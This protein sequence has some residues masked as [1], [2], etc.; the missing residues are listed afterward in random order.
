LGSLIERY[1]PAMFRGIERGLTSEPGVPS[2][3]GQ[4]PLIDPQTQALIDRMAFSEPP[5]EEEGSLIDKQSGRPVVM[6]NG[7]LVFAD[8]GE[9]AE[10]MPY[11]RGGLVFSM[12]GY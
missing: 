12:R 6:S 3:Q 9:D 2:P 10:N 5:K 4:V 8:T 11:A 1:T 7:R